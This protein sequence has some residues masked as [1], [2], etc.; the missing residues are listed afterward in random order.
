MGQRWLITAWYIVILISIII[1]AKVLSTLLSKKTSQEKLQFLLIAPSL[2]IDTWNRART[3]QRYDL[4]EILAQMLIVLPA[5]IA[6]YIWLPDAISQPRLPWF[7]RAYFAVVPFWLLTQTISIITQ[8]CFLP[9]KI[10]IPSSHEQP[11]RSHTLAE[12]WGQRWNRLFS[13]WFRQ[14]CFRPLRGRPGLGLVIAFA[15]SGVIHE[16]LVNVPL[17]I[18]FGTSLFGSMCLYFLIQAGGVF[19]ERNW[20][21]QNPIANR[22]FLWAVVIGPVP[23]VLNEGTLRIFQFVR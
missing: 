17:W 6:L 21:R 22:L 9:A 3:L 4:W 10:L 12:F 15:A 18:V 23:L 2:S 11:W 16:L 20:L 1:L 8:V 19:V 5:V 13:D 7:V 14:V